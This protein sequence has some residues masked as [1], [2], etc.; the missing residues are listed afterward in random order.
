MIT[1]IM[2]TVQ[3]GVNKISKKMLAYVS[4]VKRNYSVSIFSFLRI[5]VPYQAAIFTG[6]R[7][8]I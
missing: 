2:P 8:I 1:V 3:A 7:V 6:I 5:V 4:K